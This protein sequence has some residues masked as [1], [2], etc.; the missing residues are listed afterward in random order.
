[1]SRPRRLIVMILVVRK[2]GTGP[3]PQ[4]A[5]TMAN[6]VEG[7]RLPNRLGTLVD[8]RAGARRLWSRSFVR[9]TPL[10]SAN[11][12]RGPLDVLATSVSTP[13][14]PPA[15]ES[16]G[17]FCRLIDPEEPPTT[18][19]EIHVH[20]SSSSGGGSD[21]CKICQKHMSRKSYEKDESTRMKQKPQFAPKSERKQ[22][23][24]ERGRPFSEIDR[25]IASHPRAWSHVRF[26][27]VEREKERHDHGPSNAVAAEKK[28]ERLL[29]RSRH[30]PL[31]EK[32]PERLLKRSNGDSA[33]ERERGR[34]LERAKRARP[35]SPPSPSKWLYMERRTRPLLSRTELKAREPTD[36][37]DF[38]S[39]IRPSQERNPRQF[40]R[41]ARGVAQQIEDR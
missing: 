30:E 33:F 17:K 12:V 32:E 31:G 14:D 29:N 21:E 34:P 2:I 22:P 37:R 18:R 25:R 28:R 10:P 16:P 7:P 3:C 24:R 27:P 4:D 9:E 15:V 40:R 36:P 26:V 19:S 5:L 41:V 35:S 8:V 6:S 1:M 23:L 13:T 39:R 11:V 38:Y 20:V